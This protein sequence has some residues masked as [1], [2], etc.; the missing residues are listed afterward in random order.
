MKNLFCFQQLIF[1]KIE[2][3][4]AS[5]CTQAI[6]HLQLKRGLSPPAR[7]GAILQEGQR[8][9]FPLPFHFDD[10]PHLPVVDLP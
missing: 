6:D 9:A 1:Q 2:G 8:A 10:V 3:G 5:I 4:P 7:L